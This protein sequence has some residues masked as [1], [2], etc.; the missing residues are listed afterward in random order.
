MSRESW[1]VKVE[2]EKRQSPKVKVI[3]LEE[4]EV[5]AQ[6]SPKVNPQKTGEEIGKNE[7]HLLLAVDHLLV[8]VLVQAHQV[9]Q[10]VP[11]EVLHSR[12]VLE[13][14]LV[15]VLPVI[16]AETLVKEREKKL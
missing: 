8:H 11:V 16:V 13:V 6:K 15:V 14:L 2:Q 9:H 12:Q 5:L 4:S 10:V 3:N 7:E 1:L